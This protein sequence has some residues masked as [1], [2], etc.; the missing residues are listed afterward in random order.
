MLSGGVIAGLL[1]TA[2]V[3]KLMTAVVTI[4]LAK[5]AGVV[6]GLAA[7]LLIAG[8]VAVLVP[9]KRAA[10]VDPMVALRYE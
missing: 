10:S 1:I 2:A 8:L 4:H 7:G 6:F 3:Q 9:A 5:D